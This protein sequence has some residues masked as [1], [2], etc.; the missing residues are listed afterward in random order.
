MNSAGLPG[1]AL[2]LLLFV[3][4]LLSTPLLDACASAPAPAETASGETRG[5]RRTV[6]A[7]ELDA[8]PGTNL[9]DALQRL[10]PLWLLTSP[11][12]A[13]SVNVRT[14]TIVVVDGRHFGG[15]D[16]LHGLPISGVRQ[17]RYLTGTEAA[18]AYPSIIAGGHVEAAIVIQ[19]GN[20]N[21]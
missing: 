15:V 7:D 5:D 1:R 6:T 2:A 13:R 10:R 8:V 17:I 12:R 9:Y 19:Y 16:A 3:L 4:L 20:D 21:G 18:S 14:A 11:S